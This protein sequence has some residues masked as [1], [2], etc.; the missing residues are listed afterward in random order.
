MG[1]LMMKMLKTLALIILGAVGVG[2]L[3]SGVSLILP[4]VLP[5]SVALGESTQA[6]KN[7]HVVSRKS[8]GR[9]EGRHVSKPKVSA[10]SLVSIHYSALVKSNALSLAK[11]LHMTLLLPT[12]AYPQVALN[13]SYDNNSVLNLEFNDMIVMESKNPILPAY[14]P[15]NSVQVQLPN[16]ISAQWLSIYG[17]GGG[18]NRLQ[19]QQNG[20]YV[21]IQLFEAYIPAG[22]TNAEQIAAQFAPVS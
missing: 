13:E 17:V 14:K 6:A 20:T 2:I 19:F 3:Y 18:G 11:S 7:H 10:N 16:G 22:L 1:G 15:A 12:R 9:T 8:Q 21:R 5:S 4:P